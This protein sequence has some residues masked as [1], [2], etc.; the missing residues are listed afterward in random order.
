METLYFSE[1]LVNIYNCLWGQN[2][3]NHT[4]NFHY[5]WKPKI[6][7]RMFKLLISFMLGIIEVLDFIL[8][9]CPHRSYEQHEWNYVLKI[10]QSRTLK[11][12]FFFAILIN[13]DAALCECLNKHIT[14]L[15]STYEVKVA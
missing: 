4:L 8:F 10:Y 11:L 3:T 13:I 2:F 1:T 6:T 15:F 5:F 7:L 12:Y 9:A 14:L